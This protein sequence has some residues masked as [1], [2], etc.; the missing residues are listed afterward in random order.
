MVHPNK[1]VIS[2]SDWTY[3]KIGKHCKGLYDFINDVKNFII[4]QTIFQMK[5][6][7]AT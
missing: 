4:D 5:Q 2:N 6:K 1:K 7:S 3:F